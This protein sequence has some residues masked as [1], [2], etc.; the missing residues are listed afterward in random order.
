V[1]VFLIDKD[2]SSSNSKKIIIKIGTAAIF[3]S[4]SNK[5]KCHII[6]KLA[7]D[8]AILQDKGYEIILVSSGAVGCGKR[9]IQGNELGTKQAQAAIGQIRL[10]KKYEEIF[11][12]Y[13][14]NIAQF[15]LNNSDLKGQNKINN[16]KQTYNH[17]KNKAIVIVNEN[18]VTSTE[19]LKIGDND[20]LAS[21]LLINMDFD[22]LIVLTEIGA[23]IKDQQILKKSCLFSA[24][25]YD[26]MKLAHKGFGGLQSKLNAAKLVTNTN[27]K[28]II[29]KASD[30]IINILDK[31]VNT[32][33]F[34]CNNF[35]YNK[36]L[37]Q[38]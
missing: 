15:L 37:N 6:E 34:Y 16:I 19:E 26:T 33:E 9:L 7:E 10:M 32:T 23:L 11:S 13:S 1:V 8:L 2:L 18:D 27:K 24:E 35:K 17:L 22:Q 5:I 21:K 28:F 4:Q 3:N 38:S 36:T 31:K 14:L 20:S 25:N 29:A 12:K 30:S